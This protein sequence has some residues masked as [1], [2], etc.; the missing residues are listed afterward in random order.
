MFSAHQT[1]ADQ[2]NI[3]FIGEVQTIT[4]NQAIV[5]DRKQDQ[6]GGCDEAISSSIQGIHL[7]ILN[8]LLRQ[9][10]ALF[11]FRVK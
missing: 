2:G 3:S 7:K 8:L 11:D 10:P 5:E 4:K 6:C 9:K 1:L